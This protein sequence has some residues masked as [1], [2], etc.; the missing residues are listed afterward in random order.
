MA[1]FGIWCFFFS[2]S[3]KNRPF[4]LSRGKSKPTSCF[5]LLETKVKRYP[6][7]VHTSL[8]FYFFGRVRFAIIQSFFFSLIFGTS[9]LFGNHLPF[10]RTYGSLGWERVLQKSWSTMPLNMGTLNIL[11]QTKKSYFHES[12]PNLVRKE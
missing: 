5:M 9:F 8:S 6:P 12:T 4:Y 3:K 7:N 2:C 11:Y 1:R 10:S